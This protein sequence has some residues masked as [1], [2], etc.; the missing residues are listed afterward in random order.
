[1][2]GTATADED[3]VIKHVKLIRAEVATCH[4][5]WGAWKHL[6]ME[7]EAFRVRNAANASAFF[8]IIRDC[9]LDDVLMTLARLLDPP[10]QGNNQNLVVSGLVDHLK[11]SDA[12]DTEKVRE[13]VEF[14]DEF[15][16]KVEVVRHKRLAHNDRDVI[17][18][19]GT[20]IRYGITD[21]EIDDALVQLR[22]MMAIVDVQFPPDDPVRYD[23]QIG[24]DA[25]AHV[26]ELI[27]RTL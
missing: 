12:T 7:D 23:D 20:G 11:L 22:R 5:C 6:Y 21:I 24:G 4:S 1:M 10:T 9:I 18:A 15:R 8:R 3:G 16:N 2:S 19:H 17:V 13:A 25:A 14:L 27:R 26:I